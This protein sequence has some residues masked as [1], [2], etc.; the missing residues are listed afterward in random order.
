VVDV[1]AGIREKAR[2]APMTVVLPE[3]HDERIVEAAVIVE[4]EKL[5]R[6]IVL[7]DPRGVAELASARGLDA[8][9]IEIV[10]PA[11]SDMLPDLAR[12]YSELRAHKG[13][14][15]EQAEPLVRDP[16]V[17]GAFMV[18]N[19]LADGCVAGAATATGDVLRAAFHTIGLAPGVSTVSSAFIMIVP[20]DVDVPEHTLLF[21]DCAVLPRPTTDQLADVAIATAATRS[22]LVG[23]EPAVA[24]LSFSTKGSADHRDVKKVVDATARVR[25]RAPGLKV[26]GELQADAALLPAIARRKAAESEV[27]GRANVLI[28]PDLDAGN[29]AYKLVQRLGRA[30]AVGPVIQGLAKPV[31]DLSRGASVADIVDLVAITSLQA[32]ALG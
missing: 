22:A 4:R 32:L 8:S 18:S 27:A 7:G 23:D 12:L 11:T 20:D 31:N 21:A 2:R 13:M 10:D 26:D 6:P 16:I 1:I 28:F 3:G 25:E 30:S 9:R 14:T 29:I 15:L 17:F 24:M 5:A 19:G